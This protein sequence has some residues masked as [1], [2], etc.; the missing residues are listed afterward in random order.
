MGGYKAAV[1]ARHDWRAPICGSRGSGRPR[2]CAA[3]FPKASLLRHH[4]E[5]K[6]RAFS[7]ASGRDSSPFAI[8]QKMRAPER[9]TSKALSL[10]CCECVAACA[11][12]ARRSAQQS[13]VRRSW[14]GE[15][16]ASGCYALHRTQRRLRAIACAHAWVKGRRGSNTEGNEKL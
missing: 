7:H 6:R 11:G 12:T 3:S 4:V 10:G 9:G 16:F 5:R 2:A 15:L 13:W 1:M 14:L 8:E